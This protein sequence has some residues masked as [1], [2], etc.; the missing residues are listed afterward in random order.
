MLLDQRLCIGHMNI[1]LATI[2]CTNAG[3][4]RLVYP[5]AGFQGLLETR[6]VLSPP[7]GS[8]LLC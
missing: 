4:P 8:N 1:P 5:I 6:D 2:E 7:F 3:D